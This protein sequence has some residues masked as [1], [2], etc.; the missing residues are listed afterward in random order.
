[1][2]TDPRFLHQLFER[3]RSRAQHRL[4][5]HRADLGKRWTRDIAANFLSPRTPRAL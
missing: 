5:E 4:S 1:M 2:N 3:G